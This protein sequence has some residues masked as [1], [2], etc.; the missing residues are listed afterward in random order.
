M[1]SSKQITLIIFVAI[2]LWIWTLVDDGAWYVMS[3]NVPPGQVH[4]AHRPT[5]CDFFTAPLGRKHCDYQAMVSATDKDNNQTWEDG[6]KVKGTG[7]TTSID[8]YWVK[9]WED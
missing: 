2:G 1:P 4:M 6:K 8:V 3:Y 9:K 5:D 7:R